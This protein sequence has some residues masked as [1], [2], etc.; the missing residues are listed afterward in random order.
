MQNKNKHL[1]LDDRRVILS[2]IR[3]NSSK[4]A[5]ADTIGKDPTTVAKEIRLHRI[6]TAACKYTRDCALFPTCRSKRSCSADCE[7]YVPFFCKRRDRAPGAC[8]GCERYRSCHYDK[9]YYNPE[10]AHD[11]YRNTLVDARLGVNLTTSEAMGIGKIVKPLLDQKQSPYVIVQN[12]PELGICEKTL[13]NYIESG[14]LKCAGITAM[15]LRRQ[16]SRKI[17]K[18][19]S[20]RYKKRKDN[21]YLKGRTYSDYLQFMEAYPG[22]SIVQGDTVYN[23][24]SNGPFIQTFKFIKY[25]FLF[26][27]YHEK[28]DAQSMKEGF[29]A[30]EDILGKDIFRTEVHICL[31]DR[32]SEFTDAEGIEKGKNGLLRTHVF[33]CDP[34]RSNQKGTLEN[35]HIELRYILPKG[36]DLHALGLKSQK[37]LNK[38]LSH[39]NSFPKEKLN[40]KTPFELM[41]FMNPELLDKLLDFGLTIIEKDAVN[42]T[43][44]LLRNK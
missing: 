29:D 15:D 1:T 6:K 39:I 11:D 36:H 41:Q 37:D 8:N 22:T 33:Y 14:S 4:K 30:L 32:G 28:K 40:G 24:V 23:D 10:E 16:V 31:L 2:G 20:S 19:V 35:N 12:H 43:P 25:S 27:L 42:L 34:M 38:V 26:A 21:A 9:Y 3:N 17:T 44:S 5:I 7:H 13:Y 18:K